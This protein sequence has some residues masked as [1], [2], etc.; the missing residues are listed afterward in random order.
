[1]LWE[2]VWPIKEACTGATLLRDMQ[3]RWAMRSIGLVMTI[4]AV[5]ACAATS[6]ALQI[7]AAVPDPP[8]FSGA[9]LPGAEGIDAP[10][11]VHVVP[12][13]YPK[14]VAGPQ[15]S[16]EVWLDA[17]VDEDGSVSHTRI[18]TPSSPF[19]DAAEAAVQ[20][21][22]FRPAQR[23]RNP[24]P[25]IVRLKVA[26]VGGAHELKPDTEPEWFTGAVR[27][28]ATGAQPL[29]VI[30]EV[31]PALDNWCEA[32]VARPAG[33][34]WLDVRVETNGKVS[35]TRIVRALSIAICGGSQEGC[36]PHPD[37]TRQNDRQ[38]G[39]SEC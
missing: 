1:M 5:Q 9:I 3:T 23:G 7:P 21:W 10:I 22:R 38:L 37:P 8:W 36:F 31:R 17:R 11:A 26:F 4:G 2:V 20:W 12:A 39:V 29:R 35:R 16:G 32:Y 18:V 28:S 19:D 33:D 34:V 25:A 14:T 6:G 27:P 13:V 15:A 30:R 24:V